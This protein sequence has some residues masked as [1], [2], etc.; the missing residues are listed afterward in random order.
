[1]PSFT[2][3]FRISSSA[4]RGLGSS[5]VRSKQSPC[6]A[7]NLF[8]T[9]RKLLEDT[10]LNKDIRL[11]DEDSFR[12]RPDGKSE[13]GKTSARTGSM[14]S[15]SS[16]DTTSAKDPIRYPIEAV[17]YVARHPSLWAQ[18]ARSACCGLLVSSAIL[19]ALLA[20]ALR[21][22][23]RLFD[24]T[25]G[26]PAWWAW[27][28]A[29]FAVLAEAALL[30]ALVLAAAQSRA[31]TRLFVAVMRA[32]G[33]WRSGMVAQSVLGDLNPTK[34]A[35]LVRLLTVPLQIVPFVGGPVY[36]IVN[37]TF[38]GWDYMDRY[39]DCL[40][41][42]SRQQRVE[43]FG[44]ERSDCAALF[45]S[46]TY[47][48]E[49]EYFRFG[50]ACSLLETLPVVGLAVFPLTNAVASALWASDIEKRGGLASLPSVTE[51]R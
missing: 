44:E 6:P 30:S 16:P 18:V 42:T 28:V 2:W 39:F 29:A 9:N 8:C 17:A 15:S 19:V 3:T 35:F 33:A 32:E 24:P 23:A 45:R 36:S 48:R 7:R 4:A 41:M 5:G 1:M 21:P 31:Q 40:R 49:N 22:Q 11:T 37:A 47:S 10:L 25:D 27:L 46:S 43:I 13:H 14:T 26:G 51:T 34:R 20:S 50:F 38:V 12:P